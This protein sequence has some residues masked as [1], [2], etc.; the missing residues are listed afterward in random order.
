MGEEADAITL[1]PAGNVY[2]TGAAG[3]DDFRVTPNAFRST[4][5]SFVLKLLNAGDQI[6]FSTSIGP[7]S[8]GLAIAVGSDGAITVAGSV[9]VDGFPVTPGAFQATCNC[10]SIFH[11]LY[12]VSSV[13]SSFVSRLSADGSK[14]L[15][16]TYLGGGG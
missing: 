13:S 12:P 5:S 3:S 2:V 9:D 4:G 10:P 16:A 15:W 6:L 7:A 14:L 1:G 11:E 8:A